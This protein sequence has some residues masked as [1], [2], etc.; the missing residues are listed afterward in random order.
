MKTALVCIAKNEDRYIDEWIQYHTKVGFDNI[1]IYQNDW[2]CNVE[3]PNIVKI[4]FDGKEKQIDSYNDFIKNHSNDYD[5]VAFFDVDE[6][7]VL[8]KHQNIKDFLQEFSEYNAIG[9]NWVLFGDNNL[10]KVDGEYSVIKRFTKRQKN[11]NN[12]VKCIIK[13]NVSI[14]MSVHNPNIPWVDPHKR[15]NNGPYNTLNP[16]DDIV[17]LNHYFCK[18]KE[19]FITKCERGRADIIQNRP[20]SYFDEH[21]FNEK[22]DLNAHNFFYK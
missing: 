22:E 13:P 6:F 17:Q 5:W 10:D 9:I 3:H 18:T 2:Y 8:K 21:N 11:V 15:N 7:L 20:I 4:Q 14:T 12:H 1:F 19:E 16:N